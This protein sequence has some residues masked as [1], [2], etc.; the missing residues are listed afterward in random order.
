[1]SG[2]KL[3]FH[4]SAMRPFTTASPDWTTKRT[5]AGVDASAAI[6]AT[7]ASVTVVWLACSSAP[8]A[9]PRV[10]PYAMNEKRVTA[11]DS[12]SPGNGVAGGAIGRTTAAVAM[13]T[14]GRCWAATPVIM[15]TPKT[16][17]TAAPSLS[18]RRMLTPAVAGA[19]VTAGRYRAPWPAH[20]VRGGPTPKAP[21]GRRPAGVR[22]GVSRAMDT[23]VRDLTY[24]VR[25]LTRMRGVALVA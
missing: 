20:F 16:A 22:E 5:G 13:D 9:W 6:F 21:T 2:V 4:W 8:S 17:T 15:A 11:L 23:F 19:S 18:M 14:S 7:I 1:M 12:A 10:S 24:A 25:T 3:T